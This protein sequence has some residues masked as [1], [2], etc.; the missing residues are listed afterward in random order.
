MKI[1][2]WL[3]FNG[4]HFS[5]LH[6]SFFL[7]QATNSTQKTSEPVEVNKK[8]IRRHCKCMLLIVLHLS[9]RVYQAHN[10]HSS[11]RITHAQKFKEIVWNN[12]PAR[13]KNGWNL[14]LKFVLLN[15]YSNIQR[16]VDQQQIT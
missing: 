6:S 2:I 14:S 4:M 7:N 13:K 12:T 5:I 3:R 10:K 9:F 15:V 1:L 16:F 8:G 11:H